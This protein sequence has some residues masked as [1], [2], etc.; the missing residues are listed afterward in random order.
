MTI[1]DM[2]KKAMQFQQA[3][4]LEQAEKLYDEILRAQP[5]QS[6]VIQLKGL[7]AFQRRCYEEAV[8]LIRRAIDI[9]PHV[10]QYHCNLAQVLIVTELACSPI[11]DPPVMRVFMPG[12]GQEILDEFTS[13]EAS[14]G[15]TDHRAFA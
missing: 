9:S 7:I 4:Q 6:D 11:P 10:P 1:Q 5:R 3:G 8:G 14:F 2:F 13:Q 12:R 15:G